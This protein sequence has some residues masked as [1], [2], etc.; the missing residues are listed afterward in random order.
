MKELIT[1]EEKRES[2][3]ISWCFSTSR[4]SSIGTDWEGYLEALINEVGAEEEVIAVCGYLDTSGRPAMLSL[5]SKRLINQ[6]WSQRE[7]EVINLG[8]LASANYEVSE[9][10]MD[11]DNLKTKST[12]RIST[13]DRKI[14]VWKMKGG[15]A[16]ELAVSI[17]DTYAEAF[18]DAPL[19]RLSQLRSVGQGGK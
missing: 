7:A 10:S 12:L 17:A 11:L 3:E 2:A 1:K 5:T 9:I 19:S 15:F 13:L 18:P 8:D 4:E 14:R 6:E 16:G